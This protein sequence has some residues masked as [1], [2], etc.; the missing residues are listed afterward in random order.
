MKAA[1]TSG[2]G[3]RALDDRAVAGPVLRVIAPVPAI[4]LILCSVSADLVA[5]FGGD[6]LGL[7]QI[8]PAGPVTGDWLSDELS[9]TAF[10]LIGLAL[11][12]RKRAGFWLGLSIAAGALLVQ[13]VDLDHPV[14]AVTAA[15][16][17][18]ILLAT[19]HRYDVRTGRGTIAAGLVAFGGLLVAV[20]AA[21]IPDGT[22]VGG[23]AA[24]AVGALLDLATPIALPGMATIGA[25]L[26][27]ARVVYVLGT[28]L[29][30]D[31]VED[32]RSPGVVAMARLALRRLGQGSLLPYQLGRECVAVADDAGTS[33]MAVAVA[34]RT[35]VVLGDPAGDPDAG[36]ELMA[37]WARGCRERDLVPVVYQASASAVQRL[38]PSGWHAVQI[39]REAILDPASFDLSSPGVANLRHTVARSRRGGIRI[40]WSPT[41]L[42]GLDPRLVGAIVELDAA[43][44]RA[45]GPRLGF[46]VG[47]FDPDDR[48]RSAI[49]VAL[50]DDA[51]PVAFIVLRPTGADGGWMLDVMRRARDTVP[52]AVEACL[53]AAIEQLAALGVRRLSLGLA[54]LAGLGERDAHRAE[55]ALARTARSIRPLYDH[56][57][58]A[59]FKNKFGPEWEPRYLVVA[60][61]W[62]L[63][64]GVL[65]LLRLHLGG[66]WPR[67]V[68]SVLAG[69]APAR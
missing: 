23:M 41:G 65:A 3:V 24:D 57:G 44:C 45:S 52:G 1:A 46:T 9:S 53:V 27:L 28:A 61:W 25:A 67:V 43:W 40:A 13:G 48:D 34:G 55:R 68:R 66:S 38:R 49:A 30:L 5:M 32:E 36:D 11:L 22:D 2:A 33:A 18:A 54:P 60:H 6:P 42:A 12:R 4:L 63:P 14:S 35:V 20:A 19:R 62:D 10:L 29:A 16:L 47:R 21:P 51:T 7:W 37:R 8:L 59:F 17:A 56:E 58:L 15:A 64:A 31:P 39:G 50:T 69:L 26:V